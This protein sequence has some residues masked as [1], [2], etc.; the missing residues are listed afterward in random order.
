MCVKQN[1][2]SSLVYCYCY[3]Y[4][5]WYACEWRRVLPQLVFM[6]L[7]VGMKRSERLLLHA[8]PLTPMQPTAS[9][10][11]FTFSEV[12]VAFERGYGL[13]VGSSSRSETTAW[14]LQRP[15]LSKH[16]ITT[17]QLQLREI[18]HVILSSVR[19]LL[20]MKASHWPLV[21]LRGKLKFVKKHLLN[22]VLWAAHLGLR[23]LLL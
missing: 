2:A 8:V 9:V 23:G 10:C 3:C 15:S 5:Y 20:G 19:I 4:C 17:F 6:I 7:I 21:E 16:P 14:F 13:Q 22:V 18:E 1:A 11:V 12:H